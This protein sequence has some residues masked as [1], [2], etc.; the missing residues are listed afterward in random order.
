MNNKDQ[1]TRVFPP[2]FSGHADLYLHRTI[3]D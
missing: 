3:M 1:V 2:T